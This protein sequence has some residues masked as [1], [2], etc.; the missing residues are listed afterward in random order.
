MGDY[1][2]TA[3]WAADDFINARESGNQAFRWA[4]IKSCW[5]TCLP[6]GLWQALCS[7][8]F[9]HLCSSALLCSALIQNRTCK[10][11]PRRRSGTFKVI[12]KK[13]PEFTSVWREFP[14]EMRFLLE[15]RM[16]SLS[17]SACIIVL[18]IKLANVLQWSPK[19]MPWFERKTTGRDGE[20]ESESACLVGLF[21]VPL[22]VLSPQEQSHLDLSPQDSQRQ[23]CLPALLCGAPE[24]SLPLSPSPAQITNTYNQNHL[25]GLFNKWLCW[26]QPDPVNQSI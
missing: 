21:L 15:L 22:L 8:T 23:P 5:L 19:G 24:T 6:S 7:R 16:T 10:W 9:N 14:F 20:V 2:C 12:W 25:Q 3:N 11:P 18:K 17:S 4:N 26:L 13:L 1:K